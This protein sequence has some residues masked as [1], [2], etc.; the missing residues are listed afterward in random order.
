MSDEKV[1]IAINRNVWKKAKIYT[2]NN[3]L[4]LSEFIEMLIMEKVK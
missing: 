2:A 3:D 1:T 4:Q